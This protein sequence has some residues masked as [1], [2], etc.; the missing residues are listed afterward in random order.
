MKIAILSD[1]HGNNHALEAM[2]EHANKLNVENFFILGDLIG[3]YLQP[4]KVVKTIMSL[5]GVVIQ[6]N[7]ERI[8]AKVIKNE[9]EIEEVNRKY[10]EGHLITLQTL[11]EEEINWLINLEK[12]KDIFVD[13][14]SIKL[15][16]GAPGSADEYL[17]PDSSQQKLLQYCNED[18][19]YIF[20]G[21]TH[22]P[23]F[24][25]SNN[26][27][28]INVGS[29]G[30]SKD[31]GGIASWGLLDTTNKTYI[32]YK[33]PYKVDKLISEIKESGNSNADYLV[34]VLKRNRIDL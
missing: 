3:Y 19:D 33:T 11:K 20:T 18:Y 5:P 12:E 26:C 13:G 10:G 17:Y 30:Q 32:P 28:I 21:H 4:E 15:C 34:S 7:H 29:V 6:G 22:Y 23:F 1:I 14:I 25:T 27:A 16:H 31:I 24:F 8:I 9:L 2:L